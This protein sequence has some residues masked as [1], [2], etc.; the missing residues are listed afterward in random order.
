[1]SSGD[2]TGSRHRL[3]SHTGK[4]LDGK[5]YSSSTTPL[6]LLCVVRKQLLVNFV[7][8]T[9]CVL[10]RDSAQT[11]HSENTGETQTNVQKPNPRPLS[12]VSHGHDGHGTVGQ[13]PEATLPLPFKVSHALPCLRTWLSSASISLMAQ[14]PEQCPRDETACTLTSEGRDLVGL[15]FILL[16]AQPDVPNPAS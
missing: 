5:V 11:L 9:R 12:H 10:L 3:L 14:S 6:T 8:L 4:Q 15:N 16:S 13:T 2:T 1:M 7:S